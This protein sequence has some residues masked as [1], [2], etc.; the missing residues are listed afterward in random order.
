MLVL[1]VGLTFLTVA[2]WAISS[3]PGRAD[4]ET[5]EARAT[6]TDQVREARRHINTPN[7]SSSCRAFRRES[8]PCTTKVVYAKFGWSLPLDT[9]KQ[10]GYGR[11]VAKS[12]L[13]AGNLVFFDNFGSSAPD[14][15][16]VYSG[17]GYVIHSSAYFGR[18]VEEPM[19]RLS[20]RLGRGSYHGA[21]SLPP[22]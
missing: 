14:Y 20:D 18:V 8:V 15:V 1:L 21:K 9:A 2:A 10:Y 6:G 19:S 17:R 16:A 3:F 5:V 22:R 12:N 13:K 11:F 4:A 7:S